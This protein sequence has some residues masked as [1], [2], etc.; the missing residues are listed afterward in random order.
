[1]EPSQKMITALLALSL[2]LSACAPRV[3][4]IPP[5]AT[6]SPAPTATDTPTATVL[7][8]DTLTPLPPTETLIPTPARPN[9]PEN[10]TLS[11]TCAPS[12][13][14]F[15]VSVYLTWEDKSNDEQGFEIYKFG[16]LL[17]IVEANTTSFSDSFAT[18]KGIS[19]LG[20]IEYMI[21]A[22]NDQGKSLRIKKIISYHCP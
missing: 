7:P 14:Q 2:F 16:K 12:G 11:F 9:P 13:I 1:M 22:Y 17:K 19:S 8:T 6:P 18:G 3:E 21:L 10:L 20:S 5:T 15:Q 4:S